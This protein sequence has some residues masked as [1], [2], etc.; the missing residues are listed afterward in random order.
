MSDTKDK[1]KEGID[2]AAS[3]AKQATDKAVD[4]TKEAAQTVGKKSRRPG[5][6]SRTNR[7]NGCEYRLRPLH[8]AAERFSVI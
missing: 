6:T 4:K 7:G 1:I 3:K 5:S 2:N 8:W